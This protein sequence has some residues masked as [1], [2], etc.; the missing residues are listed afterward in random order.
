MQTNIWMSYLDSAFFPDQN[1][2][3]ISIKQVL[4]GADFNR[5]ELKAA[6]LKLTVSTDID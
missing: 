4:K 2:H 3:I 6:G 1:R 5:L